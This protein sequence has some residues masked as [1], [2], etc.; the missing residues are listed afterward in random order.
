MTTM[1]NSGIIAGGS[2][3]GILLISVITVCCIWIRRRNR[4]IVVMGRT[5]YKY[6]GVAVPIGGVYG[7]QYGGDGGVYGGDGGGCVEDGG[8][9]GGDGGCNG[10]DGGGFGGDCS[11]F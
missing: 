4:S 3:G 5:Y 8:G 2:F 7:G 9:F 1:I 10:G 11:G 6:G